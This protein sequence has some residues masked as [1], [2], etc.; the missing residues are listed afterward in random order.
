[1][2]KIE[3][4][5]KESEGAWQRGL[6]YKTLPPNVVDASTV[7]LDKMPSMTEV[8]VFS[9]ITELEVTKKV[10]AGK[11]TTVKAKGWAWAG[12]GRNIVRVDV[13]ADGGKTW[14]P[15]NIVQGEDQPFGRAWAWVFWEAEVPAVVNNNGTVEIHSKAVDLAF[16]SQPNDVAH[17]WNVRGLGNN[18]WY[19]AAVKV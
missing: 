10:P 9:G 1:M 16:N 18:S 3:I 12:G 13:T 14:S 8:A 7:N 15:A 17:S 2:K 5:S 4:A 19:K 6:N 11:Q